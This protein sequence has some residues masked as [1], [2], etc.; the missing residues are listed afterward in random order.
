MQNP[1]P[2]AQLSLGLYSSVHVW[3]KLCT[4]LGVFV[5]HSAS[6]QPIASYQA[7]VCTALLTW[8]R[9]CVCCANERKVCAWE[10]CAVACCACWARG[11]DSDQCASCCARPSTAVACMNSM[12]APEPCSCSRREGNLQQC[13]QANLYGR[14]ALWDSL[15]CCLQ[16]C[17][18]PLLAA[19][20]ACPSSSFV[21]GVPC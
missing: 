14:C 9:R 5:L 3:C 20:A 11:V 4:T 16:C 18:L 19:L 10:L 6:Q 17:F 15:A 13:M 12:R 2:A 1:A 7:G 21:C 8:G